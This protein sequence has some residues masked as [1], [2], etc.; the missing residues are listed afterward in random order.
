MLGDAWS[1]LRALVPVDLPEGDTLLATVAGLALDLA[2]YQEKDY[3]RRYLERLRPVLRA[4]TAT[5]CG[6]LEVT[7]TAAREL[8]RIMAYKDEY[9]VARLLVRGPFRRWLDS[10]SEGRV[11][12]RVDGEASRAPK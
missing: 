12:V 4:E 5:G 2:D 1:G 7:A 9:E 8:Y 10:R 11:R 3:A 6:S